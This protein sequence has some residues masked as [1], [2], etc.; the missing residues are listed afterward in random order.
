MRT[1]FL[2]TWLQARGTGLRRAGWCLLAFYLLYL[3]AANVFLNT[4]IGEQ[5]IN[6]KP[7][8]YHARWDWA[9]S[10]Y[11]GHIHASGVVM[12]GH[13]RTNR[14]VVAASRAD[15]RIRVLPLLWGTVSLG[16]IRAHEVSVHVARAPHDKPASKREGRGWT[17]D[18]SAIT[19]PS[20]LRMDFYQ[21]R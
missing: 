16:S 5:V 8:R 13:A 18:F 20:L 21:A 4:A 1:R 19:T 12:G 2:R 15:G 11:P 10:A 9:L 7:D 17:L 14:W 3:V 6:R